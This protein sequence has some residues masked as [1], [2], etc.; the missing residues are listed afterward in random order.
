MTHVD[1]FSGIGGFALAASWA[2]YETA[3]FC[4]INEKCR[5]FLARAWPGVTIH[6]D[7]KTFDGKRYA[8][9][10][11]LTAGVPCQ[12]ASR[13]GKQRG[14][15]D[16]RW[17]WPEAL[18]VLAEVRPAWAI[19]EN[20]PGIRDVGLD[21]IIADVEAQGYEVGMLDIPACAVNAPHR[22][23]RYWIVAHAAE[24]GPGRRA[25]DA[26][27]PPQGR[28]ASA[29]TGQGPVADAEEQSERAGLCA[30]EPEG[31]GRRRPSDGPGGFWDSY[32]WVGPDDKGRFRR[33]PGC[34]VGL[35]DGVHRSVLAALGNAVVPQLAYQVIAAIA[36]ADND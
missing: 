21:G 29:R 14:A 24:G 30:E 4:E 7:I 34:D 28:I 9:A 12:P 17:L 20:P 11:L 10:S 3:C 15:E 35:A 31:R 8:G 6:E 33:A 1:L 19:F 26:R 23:A 18:R 2:G 27:R 13:A 32:V 36:E 5:A 16:D 25:P 22:R